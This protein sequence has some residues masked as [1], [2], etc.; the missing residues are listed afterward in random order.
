MDRRGLVDTGGVNIVGTRDREGVSGEKECGVE[1]M[2]MTE[3]GKAWAK[4]SH[5]AKGQA[6]K[7]IDAG[8][9]GLEALRPCSPSGVRSLSSSL[10]S[11]SNACLRLEPP[12]PCLLLALLPTFR[13]PSALLSPAR[14]RSA[15]STAR[16]TPMLPL[17]RPPPSPPS[18]A[19]NNNKLPPVRTHIPF[20]SLSEPSS[21]SR[22]I[23]SKS[24]SSAHCLPPACLPSR[25]LS[26]TLPLSLYRNQLVLRR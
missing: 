2:R 10:S 3:E 7:K 25:R 11:S 23:I 19:E 21:F 4:A 15:A 24:P 18:G 5:D 17:A 26:G 1:G 13:T 14:P 9:C 22:P 16:A 12:F 6:P 20:S 8:A